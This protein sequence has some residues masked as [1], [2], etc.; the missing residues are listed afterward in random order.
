MRLSPSIASS[1]LA[2]IEEELKRIGQ[3]YDSLHIDIEDG[4]F[5]SNIT[6]GMK[7]LHAIRRI[8]DKP[9]SVHLMVMKPEDYIKELTEL[10][11][12]HIFVHG[13]SSMYLKKMLFSIRSC[14]IKAGLALNPCSK[15]EDYQYLLKDLDAILYMTSE[16]DGN[17]EQFQPLVL[18]KVRHYDS[19]ETWFD[20]GIDWMTLSLLPEYTDYAVMGRAIFNSENANERLS[21][22]Y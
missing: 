7:M 21:R 19:I 4:N 3:D 1:N 16:I 9:F 18:N 15:I 2:N 8:S 11:C 22:V 17:G 14:G 12:S 20:G 5:V 13:E 10:N 6:F